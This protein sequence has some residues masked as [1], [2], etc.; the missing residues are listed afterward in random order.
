MRI[1]GEGVFGLVF[2]GDRLCAARGTGEGA[3]AAVVDEAV[4]GDCACSEE[5]ETVGER[6][7]VVSFFLKDG[8]KSVGEEEL[9]SYKI[10]TPMPMVAWESLH[11]L[12]GPPS[13]AAQPFTLWSFS[14][15]SPL[16]MPV[17]VYTATPIKAANHRIINTT[18]RTANAY[19]FAKRF[20]RWNAGI[21]AW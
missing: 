1:R 15:A 19:G 4:D 8:H 20:V 11:L 3:V 21:A 12:S 13:N 5:E 17:F 2:D 14:L 10:T 7:G 16:L 6:G 18:S 9:E